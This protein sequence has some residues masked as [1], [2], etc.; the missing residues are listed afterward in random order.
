MD[1]TVSALLQPSPLAPAL[2]RNWI[3]GLP[4]DA[5]VAIDLR[6]LT[7]EVVCNGVEHSGVGPREPVRLNIFLAADRVRIEVWD[8]GPGFAVSPRPPSGGKDR[9][10]G[11][12]FVERLSDR[13]GVQSGEC[14]CVWFEIDLCA[15][16]MAT[17]PVAAVNP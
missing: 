1:A 7:H 9:G 4:V 3:E 5:S 8:Q 10:M 15:E 16:G 6:L 13:W 11:L 12:V 2:A 14:N 17:E